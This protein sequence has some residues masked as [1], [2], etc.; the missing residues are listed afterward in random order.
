MTIEEILAECVAVRLNG[1][2]TSKFNLFFRVYHH[3]PEI[4]DEFT[5]WRE[6][7]A[8]PNNL[9]NKDRIKY[10]IELLNSKAKQ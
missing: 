7:I 10:L 4:Y 8:D 1:A 3:Q 2:H 6:T 9:S 5:K